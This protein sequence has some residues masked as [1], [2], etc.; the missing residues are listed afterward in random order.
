METSRFCKRP[1][2]MLAAASL[3]PFALLSTHA[4]AECERGD[5]DSLYCDENGDMVADRP[6]DESGWANP[7]PLFLLIPW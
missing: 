7:T 2:A 4:L 3:L 6:S 1:L 5:L